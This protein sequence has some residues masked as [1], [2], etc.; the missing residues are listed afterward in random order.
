MLDPDLSGCSWLR[1]LALFFIFL[2][3]VSYVAQA[4]LKLTT[5]FLSTRVIGLSHHVRLELTFFAFRV[6]VCYF[7]FWNGVLCYP[8]RRQA[9]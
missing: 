5:F 6:C 9:P 2:G 7:I 8:G 3:H 1:V 4:G